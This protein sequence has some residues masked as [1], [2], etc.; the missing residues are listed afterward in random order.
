MVTITGTSVE[1]VYSIELLRR[2]KLRGVISL[3][4][5]PDGKKLVAIE[6]DHLHR[7]ASSVSLRSVHNPARPSLLLQRKNYVNASKAKFSPRGILALADGDILRVIDESNSNEIISIRTAHKR[8][9]SIAISPDGTLL[10]LGGKDGSISIRDVSSKKPIYLDRFS[11]HRGIVYSLSFS[12]DGHLLASGGRDSMI[13]IRSLGER[14]ILVA[15]VEMKNAVNA[16]EFSPYDKLLASAFSFYLSA[17]SRLQSMKIGLIDLSTSYTPTTN[18]IALEAPINDLSFSPD[19]NL[20]ALASDDGRIG[21][22]DVSGK[23]KISKRLDGHEARLLSIA[24]SPSGDL[25][26]SGGEDKLGVWRVKRIA[27]GERYKRDIEI[28][29][30]ESMLY[31]R[32]IRLSWL[33]RYYE[34]NPIGALYAASE[35]G[36]LKILLEKLVERNMIVKLDDERYEIPKPMPMPRGAKRIA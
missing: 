15:R 10:A 11:A 6:G 23:P 3:A 35:N 20:I 8:I 19:G 12:I 24:F 28:E 2:L 27:T 13:H 34:R 7:R 36:L 22:L 31:K 4:F 26:I 21:I 18:L 16:L 5:S 29:D 30:R 33:L 17:F 25:L 1:E 14:P 9:Y 32:K